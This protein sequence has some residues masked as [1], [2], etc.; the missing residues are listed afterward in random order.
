MTRRTLGAFGL[1]L[2]LLPAMLAAQQ[3]PQAPGGA[4]TPGPPAPRPQLPPRDGAPGAVPA[5]TAGIRGRVTAAD[6][7]MPLRRAQVR[8]TGSQPGQQPLQQTA[9]TDAE[10]R[11]EFGK[12]PASRYSITV[13]RNGYVTLQFGQQRPFEPGKSLNL[14]ESEIAEKIDFALP[15]GGVI[16]G[17][18]T[19]NFGEPLAG[20]RVDAQRYQYLPGGQRRLTSAGNPGIPF[21]FV[22]DDLGQFRVYGLMP[23]AY[24]VSAAP[25]IVGAASVTT[26]GGTASSGGDDG[27]TT[28]YFPGTG[29]AEEAQTITVGVGQEATATFAVVS[30]RMTR[31]SGVVRNS[32][33]NPV[34]R[35]QLMLVTRSG[36]SGSSMGGTTQP[37]GSFAFA[38]VAPGEH[39]I[40]VRPMTGALGS[41][42][43]SAPNDEFASVTF[44]ATGQDITGLV[45]TTG[46]GAT[47]SGSVVFE[48]DPK[49]VQTA[50]GALNVYPTPADPSAPSALGGLPDSGMVDETGHF[51]V[52]GASGRMLFRTR[53]VQGPA[54]AGWSLKSVTL[55]GVDITD[56]A[57]DAKP[58]TNTTGLE[59]TMTDKQ[60]TLSGTVR[61]GRGDAVKDFVVA[62]LPSAAK[63]G[64]AATRFTRTIR[65]DQQGRY[66]TKG[67]PPGDYVA[68]AVESLEQGGEWDPAFQQLMKPKGKSFRL[69]EGQSSTL[70]LSLTQ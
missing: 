20:V 2:C 38:N 10:G 12:L 39:T 5:G 7:G 14:A 53:G 54:M 59:V 62:I 4:N 52:R 1:A 55:N 8:I 46:V 45:V 21:G 56:T 42:M 57:F 50:A 37:D 63:E 34:G 43:G 36:N 18:I 68:V 40:D 23:G 64:T 67:L 27:F 16:A 49:A 69:T 28:T 25:S 60:T 15:R 47:I 35:V 30:A 29:N 13:S 32:Q 41:A 19:D 44:T 70:D 31:V 24:V 6:T 22:T 61:N 33:G 66:E 17:R 51:Q 3:A 48:G 26:G 65:P 58:S 11:Y 9:T